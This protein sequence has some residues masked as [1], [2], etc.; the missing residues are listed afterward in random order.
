MSVRVRKS[1]G[2]RQAVR[3]K[4]GKRMVKQEKKPKAKPKAKAPAKLKVVSEPE[5]TNEQAD[6][7][8]TR[9]MKLAPIDPSEFDVA[10]ESEDLD[11]LDLDFELDLDEDVAEKPETAKVKK[12]DSKEMDTKKSKPAEAKKSKPKAAEAKKSK[13]MKTATRR[14][15][16]RAPAVMPAGPKK[17]RDKLVYI[18]G[19]SG[20]GLLFIILIAVAVINSGDDKPVR[21]QSS[22]PRAHYGSSSSSRRRRDTWKPGKPQPLKELGGKTMGEYM[23]ENNLDQNAYLKAR[24]ARK[25]QY[26]KNR[27]KE[28]AEAED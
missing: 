11:I 25:D 27:G 20:L 19:G 10:E 9:A 24:Q 12:A 1:M 8:D 13:R 3:K 15:D 23:K 26:E 5:V 2:K 14:S 4:P 28:K 6:V 21:R 7:P 18:L 16:P 22:G 17:S